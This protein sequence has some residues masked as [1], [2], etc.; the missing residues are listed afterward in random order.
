MIR[1]LVIALFIYLMYR[2]IT[3]PRRNKGRTSFFQFHIGRFPGGE[4]SPRQRDNSR[5]QNLEQIE[6]AEF[7]DVTEVEST[8]KKSKE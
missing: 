6:D 3:G 5:K 1:W 2:L 7:E 4:N 8:E